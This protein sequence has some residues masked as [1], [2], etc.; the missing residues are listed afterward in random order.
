M[1]IG[2][3]MSCTRRARALRKYGPQLA[4]YARALARILALEPA[5]IARRLV[6]TDARAVCDLD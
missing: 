2:H 3:G 4:L 1:L 5:R 6:L